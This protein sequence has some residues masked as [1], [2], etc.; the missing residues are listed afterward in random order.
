M[1]F[2]IKSAQTQQTLKTAGKIVGGI[3]AVVGSAF[4]GYKIGYKAA[5]KDKALELPAPEAAPAQ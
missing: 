5:V 2:D 1:E 4:L 3:V